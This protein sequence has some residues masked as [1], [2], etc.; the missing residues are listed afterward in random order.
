MSGWLRMGKSSRDNRDGAQG[1]SQREPPI[2]SR[3]YIPLRNLSTSLKRMISRLPNHEKNKTILDLGCGEKPYQPFFVGQY[4]SYVGVDISSRTMCD[5]KSSGDHLPFRD[6]I[7]DTCIC[8]LTYEHVVDPRQV[9]QEVH[10][11]LK[12][13][14][15][16]IMSTHAV[17]AIHNYPSDYWRWTDQGLR[18]L[19]GEYFSNVVVH[20]I[21]TPLETISQLIVNYL[22][23][24]KVGSLF[25][26]L[27]NKMASSIGKNQVNRNLPRLVGLY[28]VISMKTEK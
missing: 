21:T 5:I 19:L 2:T 3:Y 11:V 27:L 7:F 15:V 16:F 22:P 28:L 9:T 14:G 6:C 13:T 23:M 17:A 4:S 25:A 18:L 26:V 12:E 20:E 8:S 10:R 1:H 24:N